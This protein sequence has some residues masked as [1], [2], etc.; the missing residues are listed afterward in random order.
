MNFREQVRGHTVDQRVDIFSFG[1]ERNEMLTGHGPF[2]GPTPTDSMSAIL[3]EDPPP[4]SDTAR[5]APPAC[6]A[7]VQRFLEKRPEKRFQSACDVGF[8]LQAAAGSSPGRRQASSVPRAPTA[9][10][11]DPV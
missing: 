5:R 11:P 1:A 9:C 7:I 2:R 6:D 3:N 4:V 10:V 8:A